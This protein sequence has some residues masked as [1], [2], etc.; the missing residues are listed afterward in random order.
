MLKKMIIL[1]LLCYLTLIPLSFAE[2]A[3]TYI[4]KGNALAKEKKYEEAIKEYEEALKLEPKNIKAYLS[5]GLIYANSGDLSKA[6]H[7]AEKASQID[8]SYTSFYNL[9][10]IYATKKEP[11]KAVESFERALAINPTS[12]LAEY[13][14]GLA[15][16]SQEDYDKAIE[17]YN[18]VIELNPYF[19]NARLALTGAL[20]KKGDKNSALLQ[21][22]E[23][24]KMKKDTLA[25]ALKQRIDEKES[26]AQTSR[27]NGT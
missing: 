18:H 10:L 11:S 24:R 16:A 12:Y 7:Y 14:R 26:T 5:L 19:D 3:Q 2:E 9:G 23:L 6:L 1:S 8:P 20:I 15:Y 13:Q 17:C 27:D 25:E 21:V 4:S 22:E